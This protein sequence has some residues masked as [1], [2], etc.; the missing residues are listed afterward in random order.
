MENIELIDI[1]SLFGQNVKK[2]R[3]KKGLTQELSK[4]PFNY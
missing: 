2:Y 3:T 1:P 4:T